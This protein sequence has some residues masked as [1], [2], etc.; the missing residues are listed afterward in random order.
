M[1]IWRLEGKEEDVSWKKNIC[2]RGGVEDSREKRVGSARAGS[3]EVIR[4]AMRFGRAFIRMEKR[5]KKRSASLLS[6][7][8]EEKIKCLR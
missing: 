2:R 5:Q 8:K 6:T 7:I 3:V 1:R 4:K